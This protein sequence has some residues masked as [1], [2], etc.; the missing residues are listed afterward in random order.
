[1]EKCKKCGKLFEQ[2]GRGRKKIYCSNECARAADRD[3][4]RITYTGKRRQTCRR[5]GAE[6]PKNKSYYC[7]DECRIEYEKDQR[8]G[9]GYFKRECPVCNVIFFTRRGRQITCST[10]CSHKLHNQRSYDYDKDRAKYLRKHPE[11]KTKEQIHEESIERKAQE[12]IERAERAEKREKDKAQRAQEKAALK[13]WNIA[14]W[15]NYSEKHKC[16]ICGNTYTAKYPL[17]K[18]CSKACAA[19]E[20]KKRYKARRAE[21]LKIIDTGITLEKVAKRDGNICQICGC[22]VD[23]TDK[24]IAPKTVVCG[25]MYPS[26][27]HIIPVSKDGADSWDNVQLAHRICNA[28]KG[29]QILI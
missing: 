4:K 21:R 3:N 2:N 29:D 27:D 22:K 28:L 25:D 16:V 11:A 23:W 10:D 12:Q 18:Y 19:R 24:K 6:L 20:P 7:C 9:H 14:H 13:A 17:Q 8:Q 26:I 5:C 1:M 15:L